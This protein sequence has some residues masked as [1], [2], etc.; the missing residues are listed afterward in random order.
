MVKYND[1]VATK[2]KE[3]WDI[4]VEEDYKKM[5]KYN[6]CTPIKLKDVPA[7][8][9]ILTYT[10]DIKKKISRVHIAR[11][12]ARG[13]EKIYGVNY[14]SANISSPVTNDKSIKIVLVLVIIAAC[15]TKVLDVKGSFLHGEFT[16]NERHEKPFIGYRT[17]HEALS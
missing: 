8:S 9:K 17:K 11:M 5:K 14:E 10:W 12:N 2:D 7:E 6:V 3:K 13:Y 16:E 4:A 15:T 1:A